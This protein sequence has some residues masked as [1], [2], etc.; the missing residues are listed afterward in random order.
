MRGR[1]R[2][3][4]LG[5]QLMTNH[6]LPLLV[7]S[8]SALLSFLIFCFLQKITSIYPVLASN[9]GLVFAK[10]A[11]KIFCNLIKIIYFYKFHN[12]A[13]NIISG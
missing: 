5:V 3:C 6:N 11:K 2:E 12:L 8:K 13:I 9:N 1:G 7:Y 10:Y 4:H